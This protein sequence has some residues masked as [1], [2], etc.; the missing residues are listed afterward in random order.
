MTTGL[1]LPSF[2]ILPVQRIPRYILFFKELC[3]CTQTIHP[4]HSWVHQAYEKLA[5][6]M[7]E[8][9]SNMHKKLHKITNP[10]VDNI[11]SLNTP[12]GIVM[13]PPPRAQPAAT[14]PGTNTQPA[15]S[16]SASV[17]PLNLQSGQSSTDNGSTGPN[18]P[19]PR[20]SSPRTL[21]PRGGRLNG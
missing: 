20:G 16:S 3:K 19:S 4:D 13:P 1:D 14:A 2:L 10:L 11:I 6:M 15:T 8:L 7:S 9:N 17:P 18:A 21:S 5:A 12:T